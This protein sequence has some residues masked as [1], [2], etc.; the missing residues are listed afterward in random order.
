[1]GLISACIFSRNHEWSI[2]RAIRCLP[3]IVD[4]IYVFDF[5]ST[6]NTVA[7]A[8]AMG[9]KVV[10]LDV[11]KL[12]DRSL[13]ECHCKNDWI[14][15]LR[16]NEEISLD[17]QNEVG[18]IF[19]G[20]IQD[21]YQAYSFKI[22]TM[23]RSDFLIRRLAYSF[24]SIRLYNRLFTKGKSSVEVKDGKTIFVSDKC[25]DVEHSVYPCEGIVTSRSSISL[26][27]LVEQ[28]NL[29]SGINAHGT[30]WRNGDGY[31]SICRIIIGMFYKL[32]IMYMVRRYFIFGFCGF[33]DSLV[34][35][36]EEFL[37]LV[38]IR[39]EAMKRRGR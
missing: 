12:E 16:A 7:L 34:Y 4:E 11:F 27:A 38:K 20:N 5:C 18:Y 13:I 37:R 39:E 25:Y 15:L 24:C 29:S 31:P 10:A 2:R 9:V 28:A 3:S 36:F 33:V 32:F 22:M 35:A 23:G 8:N 17:L 26:G 21:M 19:N 30:Y 6:D 14:L 1:M